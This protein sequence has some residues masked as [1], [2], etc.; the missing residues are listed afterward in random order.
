LVDWHPRCAQI[1]SHE[2]L[3][4]AI[5]AEDHAAVV[6]ATAAQH[7]RSPTAQPVLPPL[8]IEIAEASSGDVWRLVWT[9]IDGAVAGLAGRSTLHFLDK[10]A[11]L[12]RR[13]EFDVDHHER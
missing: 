8:P 12:F 13:R 9:V 7:F 6:Q 10:V 11:K 3:L 2:L 1:A 5:E 4:D